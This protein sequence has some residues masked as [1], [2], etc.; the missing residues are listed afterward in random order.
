[1]KKKTK[2]FLEYLALFL[3]Y[4]ISRILGL[5]ISSMIGGLLLFFYGKFSSKNKIALDNLSKAFPNKTI[6]EKRNII[7]KMWFHF[8]RVLGEYPHLDKIKVLN[9]NDIKIEGLGNLLNPLKK[10]KNCLFFSAHLGNWELTSHPLTQSGYNIS[11]I[12]RAP[13][14]T[15]VD[16]LL[17]KIR[18]SYGVGLIKKGPSGAKKCISILQKKKW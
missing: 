2:Q 7:N 11:F 13:N 14:N 15:L 16:N 10:N 17:S 1:M 9:N 4:K 12:Y 18:G 5:K 3:F 6:I 8:G